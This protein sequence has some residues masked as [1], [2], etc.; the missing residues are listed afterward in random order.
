MSAR[1]MSP[2]NGRPT[3]GVYAGPPP[4]GAMGPPSKPADRN[5]DFPA[6]PKGSTDINKLGDA[7]TG[8]GVNLDEEDRNLT[9]ANYYSQPHGSGKTHGAPGS[10]L[11]GGSFGGNVEQSASGILETDRPYETA[12]EARRRK[13]VE[14]NFTA[15]RWAQNPLWDAFL[16]GNP[17]EKKLNS[18]SYTNG[19]AVSKE[20]LYYASKD[21]PNPQT[22]EVEGHD[23]ARQIINRGQTILSTAAGDAVGDV[24]KLVTVAARDRMS[25]ILDCSGRLASERRDHSSGVV[26]DNWK[27][28]A[29]V[30]VASTPATQRTANS[31]ATKTLKRKSLSAS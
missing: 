1:T 12:D 23:K 13:R 16:Y 2:V 25:G 15:G 8:T 4:P 22:T 31:K 29:T 14:T 5:T 20:G 24:V 10:S 17:V 19:V 27:T 7:L 18:Y 30:L 21:M 11:R 26:P 3:N 9:T 28:M 6:G